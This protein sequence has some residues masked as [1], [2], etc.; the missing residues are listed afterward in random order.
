LKRNS[1]TERPVRD[2]GQGRKKGG[3][4]RGREKAQ[5]WPGTD[6]FS[7]M[8]DLPSRGK[9]ERT[10]PKEEKGGQGRGPKAAQKK[11]RGRRH[12][13]QQ[14]DNAAPF[15]RTETAANVG[16][17]KVQGSCAVRRG[18]DE[19][20]NRRNFL[21]ERRVMSFK[22]LCGDESRSSRQ[23]RGG[24]RHAGL[25]KKRWAGGKR[26]NNDRAFVGSCGQE[27][28]PR[29]KGKERGGLMERKEIRQRRRKG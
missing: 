18:G 1:R 14:R 15:S 12:F 28:N 5:A 13:N 24:G 9:N 21:G 11:K 10:P 23:S 17:G 4:V 16:G 25:K 6:S 27:S 7:R 8:E 3:T 29:K 2:R 20:G 22:S 19:L 26:R